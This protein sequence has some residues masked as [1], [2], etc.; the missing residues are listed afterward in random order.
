MIPVTNPALFQ[1]ALQ[2]LKQYKRSVGGG[3]KGRFIQIFL[4]LK[5]FQN[6]IPSIHSGRFI[7]SEVLQTL[8]DDLYAKSSRPL[9]SAV[10]MIFEERYLA[11]T[12]VT[13]PGHAVAQNTWRNNFNIQKG[14]GCY[15]PPNILAGM[16][17]LNQP[18]DQ[19]Q[20][21][22]QQQPNVFS[23]SS[24][25]LCSTGSYRN[26]QHRKWLRIDPSHSGYAAIDSSN[27]YN[28]QPYVT[29][30]GQ[31]I[32]ILPL[33]IALYHDAG[34]GLDF[35][36]RQS[37]DIQDFESDF[38][39]S[40]VEFAA[41]FDDSP[42][43]PYNQAV[44]LAGSSFSYNQPTSTQVNIPPQIQQPSG[45]NIPS[46]DLPL[47]PPILTGTPVQPP[48]QNNGWDAQQCVSDAL[49]HDGWAVYDVSR[50]QLGCDLLAKKGRRTIFVEVKSSL[51]TCAPSLTNREWQQAQR[52]Q[53][54][55]IL[56][57]IENF[58]PT[59][60]NT[61]FWIPNPTATC[62][63]NPVT[64]LNHTIRAVFGLL[65]RGRCRISN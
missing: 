26:E 48:Q 7:S 51:A 29:T 35:A 34:M 43:N 21:L 64:M 58:V 14:I 54:D 53:S 57:V 6:Q 15:A 30:Q 9:D 55:Y 3:L 17:F 22:V 63:A 52:H 59:A 33:I 10:L 24:C 44:L 23:N 12:G 25:N 41:Y 28:F 2:Q 16:A 65:L 40:H 20:Y 36:Q 32:P 18:R 42:S 27:I 56:A 46:T 19:C 11:R 31:R 62:I 8:L 37:V 45:Q 5:F 49:I 13:A 47:P 50:Q 38:N 61:A 1:T 4:G 39:F 60:T